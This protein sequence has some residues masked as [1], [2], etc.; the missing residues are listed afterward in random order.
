MTVVFARHL[1]VPENGRSCSSELASAVEDALVRAGLAHPPQGEGLS[2]QPFRPAG[3]LATYAAELGLAFPTL[4]V[5][6][7]DE[8][9]QMRDPYL[10]PR[11]P[12][13][14][15]PTC[16]KLIPTHGT[17]IVHPATGED[18]LIAIEECISCGTPFDP[19]VWEQAEDRV[20]FRTRLLV[21]LHADSFEIARPTFAQACPQFVET[22]RA[23]VGDELREMFVAG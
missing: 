16:S 4:S 21:T 13:S 14:R 23:V 19:D 8:P 22:V 9:E 1:Y 12:W 10:P 6:W 20:L 3:A 18:F 2:W 17:M 5:E 11:G 15:C 7:W